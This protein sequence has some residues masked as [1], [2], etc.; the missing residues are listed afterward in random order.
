MS[1]YKK[2]GELEVGSGDEVTK[3]MVEITP[4][5]RQMFDSIVN[6]GDLRHAVLDTYKEREA[7]REAAKQVD[8][9]PTTIVMIVSIKIQPTETGMCVSHLID[10]V[11]G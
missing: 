6:P 1:K 9:A 10:L 2:S 11:S 5:T 8:E 3:T 7:H 4:L